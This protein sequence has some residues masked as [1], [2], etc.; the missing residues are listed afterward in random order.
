MFDNK[1]EETKYY[2]QVF[3]LMQQFCS[4]VKHLIVFTALVVL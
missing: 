1:K 2:E 4:T 3:F